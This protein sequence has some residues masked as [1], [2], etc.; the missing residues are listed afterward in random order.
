[1]EV[2]TTTQIDPVIETGVQLAN[3]MVNIL[4]VTPIFDES[5]VYALAIVFEYKFKNPKRDG[6][7]KFAMTTDRNIERAMLEVYK[8]AVKLQEALSE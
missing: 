7:H 4:S 3:R 8:T 1:M 2:N 5:G 6:W